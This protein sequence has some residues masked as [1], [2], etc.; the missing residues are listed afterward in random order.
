MLCDKCH[1]REATVFLT[2]VDDGVSKKSNLCVEC[3]KAS[4]WALESGNEEAI[5][6]GIC[7]YC[8]KSG[9]ERT[10]P[11][12]MVFGEIP[13]IFLCPPCMVQYLRFT[14]QETPQKLNRDE[15]LSQEEWLAARQS[16]RNNVDAHMKQWVSERDSQ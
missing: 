14:K 11:L 6:L 4:G 7:Q 3:G 12:S 15:F 9:A 8:G 5:Q 10:Y 13:A 1:E 16:V 2:S